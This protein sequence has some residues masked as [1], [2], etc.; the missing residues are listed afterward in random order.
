LGSR[1]A[2]TSTLH[3]RHG[4]TP[5]VRYGDRPIVALAVVLVLAALALDRAVK[6]TD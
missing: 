6:A 1:A 2:A 5:Y 4:R 3:R